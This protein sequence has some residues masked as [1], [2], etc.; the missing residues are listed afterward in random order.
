MK[1]NLSDELNGLTVKEAI[2]FLIE[3]PMDAKITN[4]YYGDQYNGE[5]DL[6]INLD[7][8][9]ED[10]LLKGKKWKKQKEILSK[11]QIKM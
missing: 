8:K 2:K 11:K 5:T 4:N 9:K 1:I 6:E 7:D 10:N 3:Y